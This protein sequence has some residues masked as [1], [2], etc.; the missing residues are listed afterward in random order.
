VTIIEI[1]PFR[2]GWQVYELVELLCNQQV[3]G[4][5]PTAGSIVNGSWE[6]QPAELLGHFLDTFTVSVA[7]GVTDSGEDS[8]PR[9][10]VSYNQV[11]YSSGL[12]L[13][14]YSRSKSKSVVVSVR[15]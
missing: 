8:P 7:T 1:R 15:L 2:N 11:F 9:M 3:V 5:N 12:P 6:F 10:S 14:L 4:S 13:V